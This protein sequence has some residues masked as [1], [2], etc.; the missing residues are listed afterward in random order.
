MRAASVAAHNHKSISL[1]R[2]LSKPISQLN[3]PTHAEGMQSKRALSWEIP[4]RRRFSFYRTY[5]AAR[6]RITARTHRGA[7]PGKT[8][9]RPVTAG[10]S[11]GGTNVHNRS[12]HNE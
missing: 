11:Q 4:R 8:R 5:G 10:R 9:D 12:Y 1:S 6:V 7:R 2:R 3:I